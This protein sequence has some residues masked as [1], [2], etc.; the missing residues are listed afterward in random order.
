MRLSLL[1]K[2]VDRDEVRMR[3][4]YRDH[5]RMLDALERDDSLLTVDS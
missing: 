2:E 3:R 1:L 4:R 5:E